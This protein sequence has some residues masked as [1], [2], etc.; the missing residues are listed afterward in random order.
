MEKSVYLGWLEFNVY[1]GITL[2]LQWTWNAFTLGYFSTCKFFANSRCLGI[3]VESF[4]GRKIACLFV[5]LTTVN[6]QRPAVICWWKTL[7]VVGYLLLQQRDGLITG[8][9]ILWQFLTLCKKF[10]WWNIQTL[11]H[12]NDD[13]TFQLI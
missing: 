4:R 7:A 11:R 6:M 1:F 10:F 3:L 8:R 2:S 9:R 5:I 12:D 13:D